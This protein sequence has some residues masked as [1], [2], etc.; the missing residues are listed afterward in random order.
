M[1]SYNLELMRG[2]FLIDEPPA[3]LCLQQLQALTTLRP[4]L[5]WYRVPQLAQKATRPIT[6]TLT[7]QYRGDVVDPGPVLVT[8][9]A[10]AIGE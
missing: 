3:V 7:V 1:I 9:G 4:L 5:N 8:E 2:E 6:D 10:R